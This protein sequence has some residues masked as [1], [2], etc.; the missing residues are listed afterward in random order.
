MSVEKIIR[1]VTIGLMLA[2]NAFFFND[3]RTLLRAPTKHYNG[4][5]V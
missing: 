2:M 1:R 3:W 5:T 4:P